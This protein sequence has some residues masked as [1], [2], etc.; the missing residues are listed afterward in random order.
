MI[1]MYCLLKFIKQ[2]HVL[3][4]RRKAWYVP[5][6]LINRLKGQIVWFIMYL[7]KLNHQLV[8]SHVCNAVQGGNNVHF[9]HLH[10]LKYVQVLYIL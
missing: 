3:I 8:N 2:C 4:L 6:A 5:L 9:V 1:N 7:Q 10:H